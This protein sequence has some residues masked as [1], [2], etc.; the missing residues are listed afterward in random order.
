MT[1]MPDTRTRRGASIAVFKGNSILLIKR[2]KAPWL[3]LWSLPGGSLERGESTYEA[4]YRELKEETGIDASVEGLLDTIEVTAGSN[5]GEA[6]RYS[7]EV[8]YGRYG[9]GSLRAGSDAA[10]AQW[11]DVGALEKLDLTEGTASLIGLA[12]ARLGVPSPSF[13]RQTTVL[14]GHET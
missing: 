12:A 6:A 5:E 10:E 1:S 2:A 3:G 4:A 14:K 7:L 8:F 11:F 13:R 9:E